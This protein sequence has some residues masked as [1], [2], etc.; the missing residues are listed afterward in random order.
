MQETGRVVEVYPNQTAKVAFANSDACG[1]CGA[2]SLFGSGKKTERLIVAQNP[3]S[4]KKD[5]RVEVQINTSSMLVISFMVFIFPLVMFMLGYSFGDTFL[6]KSAH[7]LRAISLGFTLMAFSFYITSKF[8][9]FVGKK[10][11]ARIIKIL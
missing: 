4:A 7:N 1:K 3:L 5:D 8:D 11:S 2:C 9:R 6:P 10:H